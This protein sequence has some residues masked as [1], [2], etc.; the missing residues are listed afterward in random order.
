MTPNQ[1]G[2]EHSAGLAL[3]LFRIFVYV[4][5][6]DRAIT[7][8]DVQRFQRLVA[9]TT[10]TV[11]AELR[12]ALAHVR[13]HYSDFWAAYE[14]QASSISLVS[15]AEQLNSA[16]LASSENQAELR[17]SLK[18][19]VQKIGQ[20]SSP[21]LARLGRAGMT[22]SKVRAR[23]E[24]EE[25]LEPRATPIS[26]GSADASR[27]AE[28]E[29]PP[30]AALSTRTIR[31][32]GSSYQ[33]RDCASQLHP[34]VLAIA[35]LGAVHHR[36]TR[37]GR[38]WLELAARTSKGGGGARL[39]RPTRQI[40]LPRASAGEAAFDLGR[41][42]RHTDDVDATLAERYGLARGYRLPEQCAHSERYCVRTR[43]DGDKCSHGSPA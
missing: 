11:N 41:K 39:D 17:E 29:P 36:Q 14:R 12:K 20:T 35:A 1:Q 13:A 2:T 40:H 33:W 19:F 22:L 21:V 37:T 10:W 32:T 5:D 6:L 25:L 27:V 3:L 7:P 43:T 23:S 18:D 9:N 15:I 34:L 26:A 28:S 31:H 38:P 16:W 42:R 4:T 24:V 8:Y 30:A